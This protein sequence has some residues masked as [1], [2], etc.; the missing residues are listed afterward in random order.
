M[1]AADI[2]PTLK[3]TLLCAND[4]S[5]VSYR[6]PGIVATG[7][8]TLLACCEGR[9]DPQSDWG[10]IDILLA[11]SDDGGVTWSPFHVIRGQTGKAPRHTYSNPT[12]IA[13][14]ELTHLI[15]HCDYMRAF[16][17]HSADE[18]RTWSEPTEITETFLQFPYVWNVCAT[19]PGHG[20]RLKSGRLLA[21]VWLANGEEENGVRRH[22]PSVAGCIYSDDRGHTWHAG[23]LAL[24]LH[25]GNETTAAQTREGGVLFNFRTRDACRKRFTGFL[26]DG[27]SSYSNIKAVEALDDP[28]CFG[29]MVRLANGDIAFINCAHSLERRDLTLHITPDSGAT[30]RYVGRLDR[31]GGY[32]DIAC[33]GNRL[34]ALFERCSAKTKRVQEIAFKEFM[35]PG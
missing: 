33:A 20:V 27:A 2:E 13:D 11:R 21:T 32:A 14:N 8:G 26:A 15:Y 7:R 1:M 22:F 29:S 30:W 31:M 25:D 4:G 12:L 17:I 3:K 6:I 28:M 23:P 10:A 24:Q 35:L 19:G 16:I 5:Y 9:S 34:Y 18:G